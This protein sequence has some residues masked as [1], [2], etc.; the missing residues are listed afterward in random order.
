MKKNLLTLLFL[1][2]FSFNLYSQNQEEV[3]KKVDKIIYSYHSIE[4]IE[5]LAK[6]I[7][8]D[9]KTDIEK[10]R[11]LYTWL[12]L[13]IKYNY[14]SSL[15]VNIPDVYVVF[16]NQDYLRRLKIEKEKLIINAFKNKKGVCKEYAY[17]FQKVCNLL[18]IKN[19][20]IFGFTRSPD[21]Q[22]GSIPENKNHVWNAVNINNQWMF[23]DVTFGA[24][25]IYKDIWQKEFNAD[26][27][28]I[29]NKKLRLTHYPSD[30]FWYKFINQKP[31][32]EFCNLPKINDGF[33]RYNAKIITP[34][35][36]NINVKKHDDIKLTF[37]DL[38]KTTK[39][40]Y[41][42]NDEFYLKETKIIPNKN[43][44][45]SIK[46]P[47]PKTNSKLKIFFNKQ[48]ALEYNIVVS[49]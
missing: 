45:V 4:S 37:K 29:S 14:N 46:L 8:Y 12:A 34:R 21:F 17:M 33:I 39:V 27:F 20:L 5:D 41:K 1:A 22:I 24:G 11:A 43:S 16:D 36:G 3:L 28:N 6:S 9:F 42:Y 7:D 19:E 26:Y 13:N 31:L 30:H 15:F 40:Y 38:P 2:S 49:K 23:F 10:I 44:I 47:K 18:N 32:I 25:Y 48:L 35:N